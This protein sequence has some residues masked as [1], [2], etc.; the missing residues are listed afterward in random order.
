MQW[1][2]KYFCFKVRL[3]T[4]VFD[5]IWTVEI[6][7]SH[8]NANRKQFTVF[9]FLKIQKL[10]WS[11]GL[12]F[13]ANVGST[14]LNLAQN[15]SQ[16]GSF[17]FLSCSLDYLANKSLEN[18]KLCIILVFVCL[19]VQWCCNRSIMIRMRKANTSLWYSLCWPHLT[20]PTPRQWWVL[21]HATCFLKVYTRSLVQKHFLL[22]AY[23]PF[24]INTLEPGYV[25]YY[26]TID[27]LKADILHI[28]I[29]PK[30]ILD[31]LSEGEFINMQIY[32]YLYTSIVF[33]NIL[34]KLLFLF[35]F[36]FYVLLYFL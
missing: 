28:I 32:Y 36:K 1:I 27:V 14:G 26:K 34:N 33:V 22:F 12:V 30:C 17:S 11:L 24:F 23:A 31:L 29:G 8:A 25:R 16:T 20:W 4:Q 18:A 3:Y 2:A 7:L 21:I 19:F 15:I 13:G 9:L 5:H 35:T 6:P 10:C